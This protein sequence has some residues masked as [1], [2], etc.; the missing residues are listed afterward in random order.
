MRLDNVIYECSY[1]KMVNVFVRFKCLPC[2]LFENHLCDQVSDRFRLHNSIASIYFFF[3]YASDRQMLQ[4]EHFSLLWKLKC[5]EMSYHERETI[6]L[7]YSTIVYNI[8]IV[9][10]TLMQS[11]L[12]YLLAVEIMITFFFQFD[13]VRSSLDSQSLIIAWKSRRF[14][15]YVF[16]P[17]DM[18]FVSNRRNLKN[19]HAGSIST[20]QPCPWARTIVYNWKELQ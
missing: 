14:C 12:F 19:V 15:V 2:S 4:L 6:A 10:W 18:V 16:K 8:D 5:I 3:F 17:I 9:I 7:C 20:M 11:T 13:Y 1:H